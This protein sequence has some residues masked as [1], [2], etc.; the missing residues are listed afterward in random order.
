M[1]STS[2]PTASA[3]VPATQKALTECSTTMVPE[4]GGFKL[5][6]LLGFY[7]LTVHMR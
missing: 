4:N 6:Y 5:L 7:M 2:L 3:T 1:R